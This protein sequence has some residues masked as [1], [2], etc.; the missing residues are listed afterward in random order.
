VP[1]GLSPLRTRPAYIPARRCVSV[2]RP[3]THQASGGSEVAVLVG[4]RH[5]VVGRQRGK[6][7]AAAA[8]KFIATDHERACSQFDQLCQDRIEVMFAHGVDDV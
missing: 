6:L 8:E 4:R 1:A 2:T 7:S 3:V 5:R